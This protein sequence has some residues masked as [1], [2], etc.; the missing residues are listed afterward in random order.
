[1]VFA[2]TREREADDDRQQPSERD[3]RQRNHD[4]KACAA[5]TP[6]AAG[7]S[8]RPSAR[9]AVEHHAEDEFGEEANDARYHDRDDQEPYVSIANVRQLVSKH[10]LEL[11]IVESL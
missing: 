9:T 7:V 5:A 4:R 1:K 6:F 11:G 8:S 10:G 3:Q 2:R